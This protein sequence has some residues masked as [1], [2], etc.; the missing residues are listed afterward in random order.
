MKKEKNIMIL[1]IIVCT[2]IIGGGIY[3]MLLPKTYNEIN[4][5]EYQK[6]IENNKKFVLFIGSSECS[7][8]H[9]FTKTVNRIVK[10][11]HV[12]I[13]YIDISK[14][15]KKEYANINSHFPSSG[16]PTT[17]VTKNGKEYK[18]EKTRIEGNMNFTYSVNKL[19]NAGIIKE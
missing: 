7:H 9:M 13:N 6:L 1:L 2:L 10:E 17:V 14:L 12:R 5:K 4:F 16:T 8:C 3:Y 11:K 19:K 15:S 18:R